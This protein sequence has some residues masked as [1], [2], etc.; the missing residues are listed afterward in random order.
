MPCALCHLPNGAGH[1]ESASLAWLPAAYIV[2]QFAEFRSRERRITVGDARARQFLSALKSSYAEEQVRAAAGGNT[3]LL[4]SRI[5]ELPVSESA[6]RNRDAHSGFV[7]YVPEG[8]IAKGKILVTAA[9]GGGAACTACHGTSLHGLGD[10]PPL[11][12]RPPTYL[13]RQLWNYRSD[14]RR[15]SMSAP[16]QAIAA[17]LRVDDMLAMAAYLA[18]L[19]P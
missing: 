5:V 9:K 11:A 2:R 7:A 14:E 17:R 6:L 15:G 1:V 19:P 8:S 10:I 3:E 4:G 13:V 12:G 16:M 18:S